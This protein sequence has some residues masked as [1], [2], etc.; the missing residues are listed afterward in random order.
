M[1]AGGAGA[2]VGFAVAFSLRTTGEPGWWIAAAIGLAL[3]SIAVLF[4]GRI[5][6]VA[7]LVASGA[8]LAGSHA[9][10]L[11]EDR[12][13]GELAV[14]ALAATVPAAL[15]AVRLPPLRPAAA[16][17]ALLAPGG[18]VLLARAEGV[19]SA[20]VA[21]LLLALLA[22]A[23]FAL[24]TLRAAQPEEWPMAA[25]GGVAGGT[26]G[27][28][29]STVAA[30]GQVGLQLTLVGVAAGCYALV[31]RRRAVAVVAVADLVV[32]CWIAVGGTGT[33]T[34]EAYTLPA[35]VGLL[36]IAL[37]RLREGA[38]SWAAEGAALGVALVP[39]AFVV[40]ADP[41]A[42]RLVLVVAAAALAAVAGTLLHRQAP[43]VLGAGVLLLVAVGRLSPYAPLLPR[44]V[45]LGT[46]GLLLLVLGATYER[47]RQQAREAVAWVAQ[48]R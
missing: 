19:L 32:A 48:M 46:A 9:V 40:V 33:E 38:P 15:A 36:L 44:W 6:P 27:L 22:T 28:V 42:L 39:S 29:T 47:R 16:A 4:A 45:T 24:A 2:V 12:R 23:A 20:V 3:L 13:L 43:F 10:L 26:A 34:P 18:A 30:W 5:P 1:V 7:A 17:A 21:G 31:V 8:A 35:A 14:V 37:P 11:A 25:C 41:S